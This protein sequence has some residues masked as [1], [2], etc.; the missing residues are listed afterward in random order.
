MKRKSEKLTFLKKKVS[1]RVDVGER[2]KEGERERK[3]K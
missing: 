2:E 1:A 3:I